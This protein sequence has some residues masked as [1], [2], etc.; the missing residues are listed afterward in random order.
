[1]SLPVNGFPNKLATN[2]HNNISRNPPFCYIAPF[3][4]VLLMPFINKPDISSDLTYF[5]RSFIINVITSDPN[6]FYE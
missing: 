5:I 6:I 4:M 2:V 3:L 1:M